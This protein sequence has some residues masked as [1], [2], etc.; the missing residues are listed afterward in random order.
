MLDRV[1]RVS[2]ITLGVARS[3]GAKGAPLLD[4]LEAA[5]RE[6][7]PEEPDRMPKYTAATVV[8][9][10]FLKLLDARLIQVVLN[11]VTILNSQDI[12]NGGPET[13]EITGLRSEQLLPVS[14]KVAADFEAGYA[15]ANC[16]RGREH[17]TVVKLTTDFFKVHEALGIS[18]SELTAKSPASLFVTPVFPKP[19]PKQFD[20]FA[21]MPFDE[22]FNAVYDDALKPACASSALRLG[23]GDDIFG[24]THIINDVWS[25]IYGANIIIAD[26][27]SKNPNVFYELG[28][29][30]TLGKSV[31]LITQSEEDIPFDL[32]HCRY[33][34][35]HAT[36]LGLSELQR[37]LRD[38]LQTGIE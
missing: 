7:L 35:Y 37:T 28:I 6:L 24:A 19:G 29:A 1:L 14:P 25:A 34:K 22:A 18:V 13:G 32:R 30:H 20:V 15:F 4:I 27:S 26:C 33:I 11:G 36:K 17:H 8:G 3:A 10:A 2:A 31:I 23:R 12:L 38:V 9:L 5:K 21:I 16:F